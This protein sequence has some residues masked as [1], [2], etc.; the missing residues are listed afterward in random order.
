M[1]GLKTDFRNKMWKGRAGRLWRLGDHIAAV[2]YELR[3]ANKP[4]DLVYPITRLTNLV[5]QLKHA[6]WEW[7]AE[8]IGLDKRD[9]GNW[10]HV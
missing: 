7:V 6:K 1:T 4:D 3:D 9:Q 10:P 2:G 5:N 8:K